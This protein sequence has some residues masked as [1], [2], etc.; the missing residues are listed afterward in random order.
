MNWRL[1]LCVLRVLAVAS[2]CPAGA[3]SLSTLAIVDVSVEAQLP[4]GF[5]DLLFAAFSQAPAVR[6]VERDR[7]S[8]LLQEQALA[9]ALGAGTPDR[10]ISLGQL[11]QA[12]AFVMVEAIA[13]NQ[14]TAAV[15]VRVVE[16]R[17][18]LRLLDGMEAIDPGSDLAALAA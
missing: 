8:L 3:A 7:I 15:R 16:T 10:I 9:A 14:R 1:I 13:L 17:Y 18:G 11:C 6:L 12:D 2:L 4:A 5:A